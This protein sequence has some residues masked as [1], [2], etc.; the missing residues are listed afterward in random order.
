MCVSNLKESVVVLLV[1]IKFQSKTVDGM[2]IVL[3]F[4]LFSPSDFIN[5]Y[6]PVIDRILPTKYN[7]L[8]S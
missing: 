3:V 2:L 7:A 1:K 8:S 5:H 6:F 4:V